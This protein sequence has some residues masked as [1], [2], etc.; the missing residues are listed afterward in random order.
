MVGDDVTV[1]NARE[2]VSLAEGAGEV[3]LAVMLADLIRQNL[4]HSPRKWRDFAR[5]DSLISLEARD[6]EVTITLAF[7]RGRLL[8]HGGVHGAPE[9]RISAD[10]EAL[11]G[12]AAVKIVAG[13]P[14]LF[15]PKGRGLRRGLLSGEVKISGMLR[16]PVLLIRFTRLMS[17]NG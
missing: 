9:I 8:V 2:S 13:L 1:G 4:E 14:F 12:L 10:S 3:G 6:A 16:R 17:V 5:L 15:G 11:L 7:G